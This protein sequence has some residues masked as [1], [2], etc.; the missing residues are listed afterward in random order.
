MTGATGMPAAGNA[1]TPAQAGL[2]HSMGVL[3]ERTPYT[4]CPLCEGEL[5][6]LREA[7]CE[8]HPLWRIGFARSISWVQ[9][10]TCRH[11]CTAGYFAGEAADALFARMNSSQQLGQ[12]LER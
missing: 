2:D 12:D 4:A 9:C 11:V 5:R 10:Q 8:Q 3:H 6:E 1:G 7:S